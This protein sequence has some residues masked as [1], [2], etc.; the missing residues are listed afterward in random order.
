MANLKKF[1][2][3]DNNLSNLPPE[4]GELKKLILLNLCDNQLTTLPSRI[5]RITTI[6]KLYLNGNPLE[7]PLSELVKQGTEEIQ[8]Y[9]RKVD[10]E[11]TVQHN[12]ELIKELAVMKQKVDDTKKH[13]VD[14]KK[15][16][17]SYSRDDLD[18]VQKLVSELHLRGIKTWQDV[19]D[20][21]LK[22]SSE[23]KIRHALENDC[24]AIIVYL[25][26]SVI[27]KPDFVIGVELRTALKFKRKN[28]KEMSIIPIFRGIS[29]EDA[30]K[31][32][33]SELGH[34]ITTEAG[35]CPFSK[36]A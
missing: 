35:V 17:I 15:I 6:K 27:N 18:E 13:G 32:T 12:E 9:Y 34:N 3:S 31:L 20:L 5:G 21:G 2:L 7:L 14:M 16:F 22:N 24:D 28:S 8:S 19:K 33:H 4:I 36:P 25:T 10:V 11:E 29:I 26:Q 23:D 30:K 1:Y